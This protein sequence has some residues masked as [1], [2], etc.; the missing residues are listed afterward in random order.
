VRKLMLLVA[1]TNGDDLGDI[2][3]LAE[4]DSGNIPRDRYTFHSGGK[5]TSDFSQRLKGF[6]AD[7]ALG[8]LEA[9]VTCFVLSAD[10]LGDFLVLSSL[11]AKAEVETDEHRLWRVVGLRDG[12]DVGFA[13]NVLLVDDLLPE[14][15]RSE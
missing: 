12:C 15:L 7:G 8:G 6:L 11:P 3:G 1:V 9:V 14:F 5:L 4:V 2:L 10:G 13:H